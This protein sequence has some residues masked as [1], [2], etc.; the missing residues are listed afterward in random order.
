MG[1]RQ[2][3]QGNVP[4]IALKLNYNN[5]L[6]YIFQESIGVHHSTFIVARPR[7]YHQQLISSSPIRGLLILE[8]HNNWIAIMQIAIT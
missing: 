1:G 4:G 7:Q 3:D 5:I 2:G 8:L 6:M